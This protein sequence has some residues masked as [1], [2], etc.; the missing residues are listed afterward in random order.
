METNVIAETTFNTEAISKTDTMVARVMQ[1]GDLELAFTTE[2]EYRWNDRG[3]GADHDIGFYHP[4]PPAGFYALGSIGVNNYDNPNGKFASLCVKNV[5]K[6]N[7]QPALAQPIRF[8]LIWTDRGSG[9][10]ADGS[11]WRP[12]PPAGYVALGD[13]FVTGYN[14]PTGLQVMCVAEELVCDGKIG[15]LIWD[16]TG[17]GADRDFGVWQ[18]DASKSFLDTPD[19]IFAVNSF[20]GRDSH[21]KPDSASV[22][23][24]LRLPL[25]TEVVTHSIDK[26]ILTGRTKPPTHTNPKV[27]RIVTVPFTAVRDDTK[28]VEWRVRNSPFYTVERSVDY[29]LVLFIDNTTQT[30]QSASTSITT[31]VSKESSQTFSINT[32][33]TVGYESGIDAG[34]FSTKASVSL[35]IE[36]GYSTTQSVTQFRSETDEAT[37]IAAPNHAAAL[38]IESNSLQVRR[39]DRSPVGAPLSFETI[40]TGYV[41]SE[42]PADLRGTENRSTVMLRRNRSRLPTLE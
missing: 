31:G 23:Y 2:Y 7:Q 14:A 40:D 17:S 41:I 9:A 1:F 39:A 36:L 24:N 22:A 19:G 8:D 28:N 27:D 12:V 10:K 38:W 30:E 37:L 20:V 32:G 18:I 35:S 16:D 21:Q 33:I 6:P 29:S 34:G 4:I 15:N 13:I 25:P 11:C 3:S 5:S 26:P 42:Y